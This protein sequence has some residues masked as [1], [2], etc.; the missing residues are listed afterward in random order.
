MRQLNSLIY[1]THVLII[2]TYAC[3]EEQ[4][5][6]Q[7]SKVHL[8]FRHDDCQ[9]QLLLLQFHASAAY[10][11]L[12]AGLLDLHRQLVQ[13]VRGFSFRSTPCRL[14]V[15]CLQMVKASHFWFCRRKPGVYFYHCISLL[16]S[17]ASCLGVSRT[18]LRQGFRSFFG[19][20]DRPSDLKA[21]EVVFK[22]LLREDK[23][24]GKQSHLT[25]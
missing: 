17:A 10:S 8:L 21:D 14:E 16:S 19:S 9:V 12:D 3:K 13:A 1:V 4:S 11:F 24:S 2:L 15:L 25:L 20:F 18:W 23:I 22:V 6:I 7:C 5:L